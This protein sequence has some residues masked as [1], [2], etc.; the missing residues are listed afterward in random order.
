MNTMYD[1]SIDIHN[2]FTL[3]LSFVILINALVLMFAKDSRRYAKTTR[4]LMPINISNIVAILFTG[5]V[6]MA[7]KHLSFTF[8]NII[9]IMI[10][11]EL[12][13]LESYR[14]KRLKLIKPHKDEELHLYKKFAVKIFTVELVS[15]GLISAWMLV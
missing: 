7:A 14:Y 6:M 12:I 9:M 1:F 4:I 5:T 10:A 3:F 8:E 13:V 11:I 2:F 15:V